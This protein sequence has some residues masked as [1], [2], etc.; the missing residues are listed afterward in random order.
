MNIRH[1]TMEHLEEYGR[2]YAEAFS[3]EPWNDHWSV[4]DATIHVREL[5]ESKQAYG[6][7]YIEDGNVAGFILGTSMLFSY[8]RTFE[9]NDLAVDPLYQKRGIATT[10]L[11]QCLSDLKEQGISGVHLIT[12]GEGVLP[13]FYG[14][15]GFKKENEVIL[16][17][18]DMD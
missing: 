18:L 3:G 16:M 17:G 8:G 14:K 6:L 15:H 4:Q 2:I 5:L 7:E 10:L 12:A 11:K 13:E 9:I 1:C